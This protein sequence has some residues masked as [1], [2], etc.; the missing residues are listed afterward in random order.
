MSRSTRL[1]KPPARSVAEDPP[2]IV[3]KMTSQ[4]RKG[5]AIVQKDVLVELR[6]PVLRDRTNLTVES[7]KPVISKKGIG[8]VRIESKI[9]TRTKSRTNSSAP[10]DEKI[11][12]T[13]SRA[14]SSTKMKTNKTP[15]VQ[16]KQKEPEVPEEVEKA[17]KIPRISRI[18][19]KTSQSEARKRVNSPVK[20]DNLRT[21]KSPPKTR[22]QG[23][24][25]VPRTRSKTSSGTK[26]K[27]PR[28][29]E[30]IERKSKR[31]L[32][33]PV[34][35]SPQ[36]SEK[37]FFKNKRNLIGAHSKV[38]PMK[39]GL[40][41]PRRP[42]K[43]KTFSSGYQPTLAE[44]F[45]KA[46]KNL[47][48]RRTGKN[49]NE[50]TIIEK[51]TSKPGDDPP[52]APVYKTLNTEEEKAKDNEEVYEFSFDSNDSCER[53]PKKR[54]KKT[55]RKAPA[56]RAKKTTEAVGSSKAVK[57]VPEISQEPPRP[58]NRE[59]ISKK[60]SEKIPEDKPAPKTH[61]KNLLNLPGPSGASSQPVKPGG[62]DQN[63]FK[64][65]ERP[66][67]DPIPSPLSSR[68]NSPV[69]EIPEPF[70][71]TA[72]IHNPS[73]I[74]P[75]STST[76]GP[77]GIPISTPGTPPN[78]PK[79][80]SDVN[81]N[82]ERRISLTST[83][84]HV[85]SPS[86]TSTFTNRPSTQYKTMLNHSLIRRSFSPI[87]KNAAEKMDSN[88]DPSSPWRPLSMNT[89]SRVKN[90]FQ[91]TPQGKRVLTPHGI[92]S[93]ATEN[94]RVMGR[95]N[96]IVE[97][98]ENL[99]EGSPKKSPR[100]FGTVLGNV[101]SAGASSRVSGG[102]EGKENELSPRKSPPKRVRTPLGSPR[103]IQKEQTLNQTGEDKLLKQSNLHGF[104]GIPEMPVS[105]SI[106]TAHGIFNDGEG[107]VRGKEVRPGD[108]S[109]GNA[110]GFEDTCAGEDVS[111]GMDDS[112]ENAP[113]VVQVE[114]KI[115]E[116]NIPE[117]VGKIENNREKKKNVEEVQ[118]IQKK[119]VEKER[120][121]RMPTRAVPKVVEDF[122]KIER[123]KGESSSGDVSE[124]DE[125]VPGKLETHEATKQNVVEAVS[126]LDTFDAEEKEI[127]PV[128]V[129]LFVDPEPVHFKQPP[130][131]SYGKRK[132]GVHF[133]T[134]DETDDSFHSDEEE[135][136][137][138]RKNKKRKMTK[139][140]KEQQK[141]LD[142]WAKK[143]KSN[144]RRN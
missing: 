8:E 116:K 70:E 117:K 124:E 5:K 20:S 94:R 58:Q 30:K 35:K 12:R 85:P 3:E 98:D 137:P 86:T 80:L 73:D 39:R 51:K 38:S 17:S 34:E 90:V 60:I 66:Q 119:I 41:V 144:I 36:E 101:E 7:P 24:E 18:T 14:K 122:D 121:D 22:S 82:G 52:K 16:V 127:D 42:L 32:L 71:V 9:I 139:A 87:V 44:S 133:N 89:F 26:P 112:R 48:P 128:D 126:F 40:R 69:G 84:L 111:S 15:V 57:K 37:K 43:K 61:G 96:R 100:K 102:S 10:D 74:P 75:F 46:K 33:K 53:I 79:I 88:F 93:L 77:S 115:R 108:F 6:S 21:T 91:S 76:P 27:S 50:E 129:P 55:V 142:E 99:V 141:K 25:E 47:R 123:Q 131:F 97:H 81:L 1:R 92:H 4:S 113:G 114:E 68:G 19:R 45:A 132:R 64:T 106:T 59:Q 135:N 63:V 49:Y 120:T 103:I 13:I 31:L 138:I 29:T 95:I 109:L 72:D 67:E 23:R 2:P 104:L 125:R 78:I 28:K 11:K 143:F 105:T 65:I 136:Q 54:K 56:K 110:F 140:E 83:P 130:R 118:K 62:N 134:S 107:I